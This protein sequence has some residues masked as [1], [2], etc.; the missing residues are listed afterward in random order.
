MQDSPWSKAKNFQDG[1][2]ARLQPARRRSGYTTVAYRCPHVEFVVIL[3]E[4]N[5]TSPDWQ[6]CHLGC[7]SQGSI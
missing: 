6:V 4:F 1:R 3:D 5:L 7:Q 2:S